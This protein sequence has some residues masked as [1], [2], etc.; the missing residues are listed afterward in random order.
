[1]NTD[2]P[3]LQSF[4]ATVGRLATK[5]DTNA[6][7]AAFLLHSKAGERIGSPVNKVLPQFAICLNAETGGGE[8]CVILQAEEADGITYFGGWLI[9]QENQIVG[10]ASDFKLLGG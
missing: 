10:Y 8:R 3:P 4:T 9:D 6:N 5:E 1:M 2:W 7:R